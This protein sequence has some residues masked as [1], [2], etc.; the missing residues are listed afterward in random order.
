MLERTPKYAIIRGYDPH[1]DITADDDP[2]N[3]WLIYSGGI[4]SDGLGDMGFTLK[5]FKRYI[6][7]LRNM[8]SPK[9]E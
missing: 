8:T 6:A 3:E 5:D 2:L 9:A 4:R 7:G 1:G